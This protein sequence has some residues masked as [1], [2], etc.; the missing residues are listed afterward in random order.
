[1]PIQVP[2]ITCLFQRRLDEYRATS[3]KI[4]I[5]PGDPSLPFPWGHTF[6]LHGPSRIDQ[7]HV[8]DLALANAAVTGGKWVGAPL[9]KISLWIFE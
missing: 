8:L 2:Y 4:D 1:M 7:G 3:I 5:S 9:I 6:G